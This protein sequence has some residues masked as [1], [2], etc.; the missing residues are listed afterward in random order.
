MSKYISRVLLLLSAFT[1]LT[2]SNAKTNPFPYAEE[3]LTKREASVHLLNRFTFG[4]K[5]NQIEQVMALG[6]EQ[7]FY[8]QMEPQKS[9]VTLQNKL[10][11]LAITNM[12]TRDI[13]NRHPSSSQ[14]RAL[15]RQEGLIPKE[16]SKTN[17]K[18]IK[19][20]LQ[21][22]SRNKGFRTQ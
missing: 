17:W 4:P 2:L 8:Q 7:W 5:P 18:E 14:L 13:L 12:T 3:G 1:S 10:S 22:F 9:S 11:H 16:D 6:L 15:A 20:Q 19:S 21:K